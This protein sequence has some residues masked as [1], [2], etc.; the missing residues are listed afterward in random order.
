MLEIV[1]LLHWASGAPRALGLGGAG[2]SRCCLLWPPCSWTP[3][4]GAAPDGHWLETG[5]R[6]FVLQNSLLSLREGSWEPWEKFEVKTP[7]PAPAHTP[8]AR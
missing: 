4:T 5:L 3:G 8:R 7:R 2:L 6:L 1:G